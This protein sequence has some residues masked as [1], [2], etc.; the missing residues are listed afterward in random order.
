VNLIQ[1]FSKKDPTID[2]KRL[3]KDYKE[4]C[5]S[6]NRFTEQELQA[7]AFLYDFPIIVFSYKC[8][9]AFFDCLFEAK[10][11]EGNAKTPLYLH[12]EQGTSL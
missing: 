11:A 12:Y 9:M 6:N 7:A 1:E 10:T 8:K 4:Q 5:R 2:S 3:L